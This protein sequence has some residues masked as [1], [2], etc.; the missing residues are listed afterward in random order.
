[1]I[2][3]GIVGVAL[4]LTLAVGAVDA[5]LAVQPDVEC[6]D[7]A[8]RPGHSDTAPGSPFKEGGTAGTVYAGEQPQNTINEQTESQYD[9]ACIKVQEHTS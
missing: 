3:R 4:G 7:V 1:M 5:A 2:R 8:A 9:V 6:E